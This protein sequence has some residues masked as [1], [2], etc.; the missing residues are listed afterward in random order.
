MWSEVAKAAVAF[1]H[2]AT[3][4]AV[5]SESRATAPAGQLF[6]KDADWAFPAYDRKQLLSSLPPEE[7][8]HVTKCTSLV[9]SF[10]QLFHT[11]KHMA[12][13]DVHHTVLLSGVDSLCTPQAGCYKVLLLLKNEL[14]SAC[15]AGRDHA[16][17]FLH[18]Q[19]NLFS[20]ATRQR[21]T[22]L[23]PS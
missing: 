6:G 23:L 12:N 21:G 14:L 2:A 5:L 15:W 13:N 7:Q 3:D 19:V 1:S 18:A 8:A 22:H 16:M 17:S 11:L 10:N 4:F 20:C 9:W